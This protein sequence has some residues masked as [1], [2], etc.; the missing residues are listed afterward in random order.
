MAVDEPGDGHFQPCVLGAGVARAAG[1]HEAGLGE[2]RPAGR[3]QVQRGGGVRIHGLA[4][5]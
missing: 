5:S 4:F 2:K 1:E 3:R